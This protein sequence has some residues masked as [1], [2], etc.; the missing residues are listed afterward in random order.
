MATKFEIEKSNGNNDFGLWHLKMHA[1]LVYNGLHKA[2]KGKNNLP[3]KLSE[4]E[5][6]ELLE[7]AYGQILLFFSD[8]VLR[9]V[10]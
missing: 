10:A 6:D 7:K 9:K 3:E 2:L 5:N 1:L 8:G 4:E